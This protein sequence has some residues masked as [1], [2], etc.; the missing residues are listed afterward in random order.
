MFTSCYRPLWLLGPLPLLVGLCWLCELPC[1]KVCELVATALPLAWG[2]EV[3]AGTKTGVVEDR[4]RAGCKEPVA[5][6][7]VRGLI[8]NGWTVID[9]ITRGSA[10]QSRI[11][12]LWI[13]CSRMRHTQ[14]QMPLPPLPSP[15]LWLLH[16][17]RW[18][19]VLF[20]SSQKTTSQLL[21]SLWV[22]LDSDWTFPWMDWIH[23]G[24]RHLRESHVM[25]FVSIK[26]LIHFQNNWLTSMSSKMW[27]RNELKIFEE[28]IPEF[29]SI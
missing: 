11:C 17:P 1:A 9:L 4:M 5:G 7:P 20:P 21:Q 24:R 18:T 29:F 25:K 22:V 27:W 15:P 16:C 13:H 23:L 28:N 26:G 3:P 2:E 14:L 8:N 12:Y 6:I 19:S 10:S